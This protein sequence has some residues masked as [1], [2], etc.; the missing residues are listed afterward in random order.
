MPYPALKKQSQIKIPTTTTVRA[1]SIILG[2]RFG[3]HTCNGERRFFKKEK[4]KHPTRHTG[5]RKFF[6]SRKKYAIHTI[7]LASVLLEPY[8]FICNLLPQDEHSILSSPHIECLHFFKK[9]ML[10]SQ[11]GQRKA[12]IIFTSLELIKNKIF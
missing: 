9:P 4:T 12:L 11:T 5:N 3:L 10:L 8:F 2:I 7:K 1:S 6:I